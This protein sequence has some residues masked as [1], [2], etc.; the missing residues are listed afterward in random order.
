MSDPHIL[1][2]RDGPF[3]RV[4]VTPADALPPSVRQPETHAGY[5]SVLMAAHL[6]ASATG[7]PIIDETQKG[8]S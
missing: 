1:L 3:Y 6:L 5:A 2:R 8:G 7:F 4:R